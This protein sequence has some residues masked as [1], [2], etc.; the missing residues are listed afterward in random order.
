[1]RGGAIHRQGVWGAKAKKFQGGGELGIGPV[2]L[3]VPRKH[4]KNYIDISPLSSG[5]ECRMSKL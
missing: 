3:A 4:P 1:M 5:S 2:E